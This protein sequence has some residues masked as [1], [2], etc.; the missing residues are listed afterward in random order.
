MRDA[1]AWSYDLLD[2]AE[3]ALFRRL[4]VFAGGCAVEA[5]EAVC[6]DEGAGL[7][8]LQGL[9]ALVDKSLL[10][11]QEGGQVGTVEPRLTMLETI[12]EYAR[13]RL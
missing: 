9:A 13:E 11:L 8:V 12:R 10:Q 6:G 2:P 4:S 5:A 3:Q 7:V 1:I